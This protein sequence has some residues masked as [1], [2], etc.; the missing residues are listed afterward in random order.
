MLLRL[1]KG[2]KYSFYG[3]KLIAANRSL[4]IYSLVPFLLQLVLLSLVF[5]LAFFHLNEISL[6]VSQR[7][8]GGLEKC[9]LSSWYGVVWCKIVWLTFLLLKSLIFLILFILA[10]FIFYLLGIILASPIYDLISEKTEKIISGQA[11]IPFSFKFLIKSIWVTVQVELKKAL[12]LLFIALLGLLLGLI[13]VAGLFLSLIVINLTAV[14]GF[15]LTMV[16]YPMARRNWSFGR[17]LNFVKN[18]WPELT[19]FGLVFFIPLLNFLAIPAFVVGAT[20]L[21]VDGDRS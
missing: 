13:P 21:F 12:L 2:I 14:F 4:L 1:K 10:L 3:F 7:F 9:A 20:A 11:E 6:A 19:G 16:D 8:F 5:Y 17:R 15:S 18:R